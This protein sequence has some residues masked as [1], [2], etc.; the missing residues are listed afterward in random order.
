MDGTA[1]DL[2]AE[3]KNPF[4]KDFCVFIATLLQVSVSEPYPNSDL[5]N[6]QLK[7]ASCISSKYMHTPPKGI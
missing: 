4:F 6:R 1:F 7:Y 5:Y 3:E 2:S